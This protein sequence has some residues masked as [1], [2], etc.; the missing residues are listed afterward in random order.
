VS[1]RRQITKQAL[2][3][4]ARKKLAI[5][6]L[7]GKCAHCGNDD[8]RVLEFDHI[9]PL[10][11]TGEKRE[12]GNQIAGIILA[13]PAPHP[14]FQL[15]CANCHKIKTYSDLYGFDVEAK[16]DAEIERRKSSSQLTAEKSRDIGGLTTRQVHDLMNSPLSDKYW[17]NRLNV[18]LSAVSTVR[19][20]NNYGKTH[21][22][23]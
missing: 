19:R 22:H 10:A 1:E 5:E 15:L 3:N 6:H 23:L 17:G 8:Y 9:V 20:T 2:A 7:G 13:E 11:E 21:R 16:V 4:R 12:R 18:P 14:R